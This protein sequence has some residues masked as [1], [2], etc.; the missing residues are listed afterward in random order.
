ME[1]FLGLALLGVLFASGALFPAAQAQAASCYCKGVIGV[2]VCGGGGIGGLPK[3]TDSNLS[4]EVV[5]AQYLNSPFFF[6]LL[7]YNTQG[8]GHDWLFTGWE[9][10]K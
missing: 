1:K 3:Q 9:C 6:A 2:N 4:D 8:K 5:K 7:A 10:T